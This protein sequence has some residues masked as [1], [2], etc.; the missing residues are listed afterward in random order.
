MGVTREHALGLSG[1][2]F[3]TVGSVVLLGMLSEQG[4]FSLDTLRALLEVSRRARE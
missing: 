4:V 2:L 3:A 1:M